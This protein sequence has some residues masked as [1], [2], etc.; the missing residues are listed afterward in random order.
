MFDTLS[1]M[2][3][4]AQHDPTR[5]EAHDQHRRGVI[6]SPRATRRAGVAHRPPVQTL[7]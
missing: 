5:P 6:T 3:L 7:W 2:I 4:D 1:K